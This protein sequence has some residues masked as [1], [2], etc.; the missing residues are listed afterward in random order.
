MRQWWKAAEWPVIGALAVLA[1]VLGY[2]GFSKYYSRPGDTQ[3]PIDLLYMTF[4]LFFMQTPALEG[5]IPRTLEIARFLAPALGLY[6]ALKALAVVFSGQLQ[7]L[8]LRLT[9]N[10]VVVCGVGRKGAA[11]VESLRAEGVRVVA[12]ERDQ[13][14][15]GL[16]RAQECGAI[17][18]IGDAADEGVL[19]RANVAR[20][21][22][23]ACMGDDSANAA[24]AFTAGAIA[25]RRSRSRLTCH[26]HVTDFEVWRLL[27]E[28]GLSVEGD[29]P[30]RLEFFNAYEA[31]AAILLDPN[32]R[33]TPAAAGGRLRPHL[34]IVGLGNLGQ[35][36]IVRATTMWRLSG[37]I[38]EQRPLI[39]VIDLAAAAKVD[40]L[41]VR[42][43]GLDEACDVLPHDLDLKS[44][45]FE[46]ADFLFPACETALCTS[47][48]ICFNDDRRTL[49]AALT[50][51]QRARGGD[52]PIVARVSSER[53]L[54]SL[55][56]GLGTGVVAFP[57]LA[58]TC[59]SGRL[60]EGTRDRLA[61][62][63]LERAA[64]LAHAGEPDP[65]TSDPPRWTG[66]TERQRDAYR[67]A[68]DDIVDALAR[69]GYALA[70]LHDWAAD[71]VAFSEDEVAMMEPRPERRDRV[72]EAPLV[73]SYAGFTVYRPDEATRPLPEEG[74]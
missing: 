50:L 1:L 44:A 4:Q 20:A 17:T 34:V 58:L 36:I 28:R 59:T 6:T 54:A 26:V 27:H 23:I 18:I 67:S 56:D 66:L 31:G 72:R 14:Q 65:R 55:L 49:Q 53:G 46:R 11:L 57:L 8:R 10:H 62:A 21:S 29:G 68:A 15:P 71:P 30:L 61:Q 73:L 43:A 41:R 47:V 52:L 51:C 32:G 60:R 69:G 22:R 19:R 3:D 7:L 39:T 5:S 16:N 13:A 24:I 70:P 40:A 37:K 9:H 42:F 33:Y 74:P 64:G 25:R 2:I 45:E 38:V 35:S 63:C 12:I 48:Y